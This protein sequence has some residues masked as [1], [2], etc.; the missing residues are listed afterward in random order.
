MK[1]RNQG[2]AFC[3]LILVA[4]IMNGCSAEQPQ[5]PAAVTTDSFAESYEAL[6]GT[7]NASGKENRTI[8][9]PADHP[10]VEVSGEDIVTK[11]EAKETFYVLYSDAMCPWCRSVIETAAACAKKNSISTIYVVDLW[12]DEGNEVFRD[13]V[14][15][16]DGVLTQTVKGTD[17]YAMTLT[18]FQNV[19][20]EYTVTDVNGT[21]YDVGEKRI[22]APNFIY[23]K[24]GQPVVLTEGI[25]ELQ[26]DAREE[27]SDAILQ[28]EQK[29]LNT[30][31]Q[32]K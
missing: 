11:A 20:N 16:K 15:V 10:F 17:A 13:K 23:V 30:F 18:L 31:F 32:T 12:D 8:H 27:L 24:D 7:I 4:L 14:E 19:L 25:S 2:R 9:L 5:A 3:G 21:K 29:I 6:N 1:N 26:T 22:F 28:D